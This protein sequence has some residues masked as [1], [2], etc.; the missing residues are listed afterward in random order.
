MVNFK[1]VSEFLPWM[2]VEGAARGAFAEEYR[3]GGRW[4]WPSSSCFEG[5]ENR[6]K[7]LACVLRI[8]WWVS[9]CAN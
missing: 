4:L 1:Y 2:M 5:W 8:P 9:P 7:G 6:L 3:E